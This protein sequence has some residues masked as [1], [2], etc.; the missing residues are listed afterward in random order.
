MTVVP[1]PSIVCSCIGAIVRL[2]IC[3]FLRGG[4]QVRL[5][6][7]HFTGEVV[8]LKFL[9]VRAVVLQRVHSNS[10]WPTARMFIGVDCFLLCSQKSKLGSTHD[11]ERVL[12]EIRCFME[13]LHPNIIR[14]LQVLDQDKFV[15]LVLEYAP[16]GDLNK[17]LSVCEQQTHMRV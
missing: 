3:A 14:L 9:M 15:V 4:W 2:C 17:H 10:L 12:T 13:L 11:A 16:G 6:R 8:A 1:L 5:G 7:N